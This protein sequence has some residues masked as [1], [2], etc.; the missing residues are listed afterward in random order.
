M[1]SASGPASSTRIA[2]QGAAKAPVSTPRP[3]SVSRGSKVCLSKLGQTGTQFQPLPDQYFGG[4]CTNIGTVRLSSIRGD[5]GAFGLSNVGPLQC[6]TAQSF[7]AWARYGVDRA[8]QEILGSRLQKIE[9]MGT[10]SCRNVAGSSRRSA[11][12]TA[13]A[14]DVSAFVLADGRR[15]SLAGDWDGGSQ[16]ERQFLR[17][18]HRS[19]CKRFGTVL[20]PDYNAAHRDHFHMERSGRGFC[21]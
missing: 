4:G 1:P 17:T 20:G 15:I 14:I 6:D 11:H 16:K 19:A 9:T 13:E 8:A 21:R 2:T 7:T 18:V 12:A 3:L 10:Y 5:D